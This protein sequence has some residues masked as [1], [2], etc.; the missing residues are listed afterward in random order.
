[1]SSTGFLMSTAGLT[2]MVMG[3]ERLPVSPAPSSV[4]S[5]EM[6]DETELLRIRH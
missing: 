1:M 2:E 6:K 5:N 4:L 3:Q